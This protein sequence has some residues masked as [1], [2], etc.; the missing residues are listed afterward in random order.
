MI[1]NESFVWHCARTLRIQWY[2]SDVRNRKIAF[3]AIRRQYEIR[4]REYSE[5]L[6]MRI[7]DESD[8]HVNFIVQIMILM[9]VIKKHHA[10]CEHR[11]APCHSNRMLY[12]H[13]SVSERK[14]LKIHIFFC[15]SQFDARHFS[16]GYW[17]VEAHIVY[18]CE[19]HDSKIM[20]F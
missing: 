8:G 11:Y 7:R 19:L 18:I 12:D 4:E 9:F 16:V 14:R 3:I 15:S 5:A 10:I 2:L 1:L 13:I 17:I 20:A 6:Y